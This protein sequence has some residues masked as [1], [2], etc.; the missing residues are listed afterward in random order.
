M[1]VGILPTGGLTSCN[2]QPS[3][4]DVIHD[5]IRRRQHHIVAIADIGVRI[6]E[7]EQDRLSTTEAP[8]FLVALSRYRPVLRLVPQ[9]GSLI[10]LES[11]RVQCCI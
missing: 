2:R 11:E 10:A 9:I 4:S 3:E 6:N 8:D 7:S 5:H 1:V